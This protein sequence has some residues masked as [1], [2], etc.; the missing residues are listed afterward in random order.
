M[1]CVKWREVEWSEGKG[2]GWEG[3]EGKGMSLCEAFLDINLVLLILLSL[4][5]SA[6]Q[7]GANNKENVYWL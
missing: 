2:R 4:I 6:I 5:S 1:D 7:R 3:R